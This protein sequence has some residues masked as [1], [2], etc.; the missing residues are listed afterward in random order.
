MEYRCGKEVR[1]QSVS[2]QTWLS[3]VAFRRGTH[4][5]MAYSRGFN[6]DVVLNLSTLPHHFFV[7]WTWHSH[8]WS[9]PLEHQSK[10]VGLCIYSGIMG[11]GDR[12]IS[13]HRYVVI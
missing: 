12:P 8:R 4:S 9:L 2:A 7:I 13:L 3:V 11:R 5:D 10:R 6:T 1:D